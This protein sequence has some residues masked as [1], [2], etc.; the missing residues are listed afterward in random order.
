MGITIDSNL[1]WNEHIRNVH[2]T[3]SRNIGILYKLK[4][5]LTEKCLFTMYNSLILSH[6]SYCN[7]VW[8][9]CGT[10]KINSLL[11]LQKRAIRIITNS[12]YLSHTDPL[13]QRLKTLKIQD[14]HTLQTAI[15]MYKYTM[16]LLPQPFSN[17]FN[18]NS[19]IHFHLTRHSDDYH[20]ENPKISLAHKS[21]RHH[22]P[23]IWN[24]LPQ[25]TRKAISLN[26]FKASVKKI[27]YTQPT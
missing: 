17:L 1:N 4:D 21:I 16:K 2:T 13:F 3:I 19:N 5:I 22:G 25:S 18:L 6:I 14:I 10:I 26:S 27:L 9:N 7:I 20:L 12:T 24:S 15:F 8:G 23:D 11:L